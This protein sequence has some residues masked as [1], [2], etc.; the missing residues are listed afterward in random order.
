MTCRECKYF[1]QS[2][3]PTGGLIPP[4]VGSCVAPVQDVKVPFSVT[5]SITWRWPPSRVCVWTSD[6]KDCQLFQSKF[7]IEEPP[8][9]KP[10]K[11]KSKKATKGR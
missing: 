5:N 7:A 6:G 8:K 4:G 2:Q 10:S 9:A 3:M 11:V 1:Q